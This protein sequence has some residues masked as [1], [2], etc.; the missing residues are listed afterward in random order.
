MPVT[1][2]HLRLPWRLRKRTFISDAKLVKCRLELL[3]VSL[4]YE[5]PR[6]N[7][8]GGACFRSPSVSRA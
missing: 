2:E 5:N 7:R 3:L 8:V 4:S 1:L 6:E